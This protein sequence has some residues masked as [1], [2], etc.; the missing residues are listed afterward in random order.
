LEVKVGKRRSG[1]TDYWDVCISP[2]YPSCALGGGGEEG[3]PRTT[4]FRS[5]I[6][7]MRN[8]GRKKRKDGRKRRKG[9]DAAAA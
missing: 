2:V 5:L 1:E 9:R 8:N 6:L 4:R 3:N 7:A